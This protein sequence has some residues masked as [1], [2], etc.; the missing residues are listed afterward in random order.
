MDKDGD[1]DEIANRFWII[2][3]LLLIN[4]LLLPGCSASKPLSANVVTLTLQRYQPGKTTFAQF[5]NDAGLSLAGQTQASVDP[6]GKEPMAQSP[7]KI[8]SYTFVVQKQGIFGGYHQ[9]FQ[10]MVGDT[11]HPISFLAFNRDGGLVSIAPVMH[12]K[13]SPLDAGPAVV[14]STSDGES[15]FR[16]MDVGAVL[17]TLKSYQVGKTTFGDFKRDAGLV[18]VKGSDYVWPGQQFFLSQYVVPKGS[19]W[20]LYGINKFLVGG[21]DETNSTWTFKVGDTVRPIFNLTF[22]G[23]GQLVAI[24]PAK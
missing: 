19:A 4:F 2:S 9:Q 14:L 12:K 3:F 22:L 13:S 21:R 5:R 15:I 1:T 6:D 11:D 16:P 8:Y 7:W 17:A 20:Q 23:T 18:L 24:A 10:Y